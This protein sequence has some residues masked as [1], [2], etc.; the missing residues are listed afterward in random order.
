MLHLVKIVHLGFSK[1][2][3]FVYIQAVFAF[4]KLPRIGPMIL[5]AN[6]GV[7]ATESANRK[8]SNA[9]TMAYAATA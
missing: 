2:I 7:P 4:L 1:I 5:A 6:H 8:G 3:A 9:L